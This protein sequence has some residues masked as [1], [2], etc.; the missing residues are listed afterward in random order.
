[1]RSPSSLPRALW[2]GGLVALCVLCETTPSRA[3]SSDARQASSPEAPRNEAVQGEAAP[4]R[5]GVDAAGVV[6]PVPVH[7]PAAAWPAGHAGERERVVPV[8]LT[9]GLE[10][11]V[12][13]ATL[14]GDIEEPFATLA[15][16]TALRFRFVPARD[17]RGPRRAR[18]RALV[19]FPASQV[20]SEQ[21]NT[22]DRNVPGDQAHEPDPTGASEDLPSPGSDEQPVSILVQGQTTST[23][24]SEVVVDRRMLSAAP[25]KN[26]SELLLEVPGVF[27][28]QHGGE[29]KAHQI[30]FR[31]F[32]AVHGQDVELWVAGA[33]VNDV[34]NIHGQGYAD[35]HFLIP[36]VVS[37]IRALPGTYSVEQGDFAVAGS[38]YFELGNPVPGVR[39]GAG[40]GSFGT[41]RA[42]L[43]YRPQKAPASTFGALELYSTNGFG[44]SRAARHAS[45]LGQA[46]YDF[47]KGISGRLMASTYAGRFDSAGVLLSSDI[48]SGKLDRF[49]SYDQ[50]QGGY[51]QRT[52]LVASLGNTVAGEALEHWSLSPF[53]VFRSLELRSNFTGY[54]TSPE[55]DSIEQVNDATSVGAKAVYQRS[56]RWFSDRDSLR[57]GLLLRYDSIDQSQHR[58][59][60]GTDE[61]T[62]DASSPGVD[63]EVRATDAAGYLGVDLHPVSRLGLQAGLRADG[64][65]YAT[66]DR[67]GQAEGQ[68]RTALGAQLSKRAT[69]TATVTSALDVVASYGEGFRSPQARGLGDA[70]TTPFTRV[71]SYELGFRWQERQRF[72]ASLAAYRTRLSDD[73]VFDQSTARNELV[74]GTIRTGLALH[75]LAQPTG[76]FLSNTSATYARATFES[77][78]EKYQEGDLLP[79]VP[80]LVVRSEMTL[81]EQ[82]GSFW[83]QRLQSRLG[84]ALTYVGQRPLPYS[85][86]GRDI[87][88]VD[89][90]ATLEWSSWRTSLDVFNVLDADWYDGEFVYASAF[91]GTASLVPRRH[92][93]V[94]APR[95]IFW[96]LEVAI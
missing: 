68:V 69:A 28:S 61:V 24:A 62:D 78:S 14:E 16:E 44:P 8:V 29:G 72:R 53:V 73:L 36:E 50:S 13:S 92:V 41:R 27:I 30:F 57:A 46:S 4:A 85:E 96:S 38:L 52:Q 93:T 43:T 10:G 42:F 80:E 76:W 49:A 25:H 86:M 6:P 9:V 7:T 58:L 18:I 15:L 35:L 90:L 77:S 19:R 2:P 23:S 91:D 11:R 17:A 1:M 32:D 21:P 26:G 70:E 88:L 20:V 82:W 64:L 33:P 5:P 75:M 22:S 3:V 56:L 31:G 67:G 47:G 83:G 84:G 60:L 87:F 79:Y 40:S 37:R 34:S 48:E 71:V 59:S 55:G 66:R 39:V 94:G 89:A 51:S 12:E 74:P 65:S 63:A 54:L 45:A 95:T 81:H